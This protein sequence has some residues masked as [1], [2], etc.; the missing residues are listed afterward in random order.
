MIIF[1]T[2]SL[3]ST[4]E[5]GQF[6]CPRCNSLKNY[7]RIGVNRFFTLYFI[8]LIPLGRIGSYVE[9]SSCAQTYA[10]EVLHYNPIVDQRESMLDFRRILVMGMLATAKIEPA[11]TY[12][13]RQ[14]Y[15]TISQEPLDEYTAQ[16]DFR[17][18]RESGVDPL[19]FIQAQ[20]GELSVDGKELVLKC[21][22]EI[23]CPE[24]P[25]THDLQTGLSHV[26]TSMGFPTTRF[27][28]LMQGAAQ[29]NLN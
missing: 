11:N 23:T 29:R 2:T 3:N 19:V 25:L 13:L 12:A 27:D 1:G 15:E 26:S 10:E 6:N 5:S 7:K 14:V 16:E 21:M 20:A 4:I 22:I 9:C 28:A 18:A 8:P 17:M 24:G